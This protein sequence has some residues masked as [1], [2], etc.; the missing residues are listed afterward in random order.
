MSAKGADLEPPPPCGGGTAPGRGPAPA[1]LAGPRRPTCRRRL[2]PPRRGRAARAL[3]A[4]CLSA[5]RCS[6]RAAVRTHLRRAGCEA[7]P[8]DSSSSTNLA[9]TVRSRISL[10]CTFLHQAHGPSNNVRQHKR[11]A[12]RNDDEVP[13]RSASATRFYR[14]KYKA[15]S[16]HVAMLPRACQPPPPSWRGSDFTAAS[17]GDGG[18]WVVSGCVDDAPF[19][20]SLR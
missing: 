5:G 7:A 15:F 18:R 6:V 4:R 17:A 10:A 14:L 13:R 1:P 11:V 16:P 2:R 9:T 19:A 20:P 8:C 3:R 12:P